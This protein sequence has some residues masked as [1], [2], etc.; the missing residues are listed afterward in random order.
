MTAAFLRTFALTIAS[1]CASAPAQNDPPEAA[2]DAKAQEPEKP[3]NCGYPDRNILSPFREPA[4]VYAPPDELFRQLRIMQTVA[5]RHPDKVSF[6]AEGREQVDD[7]TWR[8]AR[9]RVEE[10]DLQAGNLAQ[11]MRL[12]RDAGQRELAFFAAFYCHEVDYV[13][14]LIAHIPGEPIRAIRESAMPRAV[15]YVRAH[16]GRRFGELSMEQQDALRAALPEP[17]SPMARARGIGRAPIDSDRLHTLNLVPFFQLLDTPNKLDHA[18]ALWFLSQVFEIRQDLALIWLE[19]VLPRIL[20]LLTG[21]DAEVQEQAIAVLRTIGS[22]KLPEAPI[23]GDEAALLAWAE[24]ATR[25]LFPPIR[26]LNDAIVQLHPSPERDAIVAAGIAALA[27]SSLG[28]PFRGQDAEN[29]WYAG[30]RILRVPDELKPLA[31]PVDAVI[32]SLNGISTPD[33]ATLLDMVKRVCAN[34]QRPVKMVVE[35]RLQGKPHAI[36]YRVM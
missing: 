15:A 11:M 33:A 8:A 5:S 29:K 22:D 21:D 34:P 19:P 17:G 24:Q 31:L 10:L 13:M 16:L 2:A 14:E 30:Y 3:V 23:D 32:T 36:E 12:H 27:H 6:D 25:N 4:D 28:D 35:Y 26:N 18:Q 9:I 7:Q 1:L 20:Q